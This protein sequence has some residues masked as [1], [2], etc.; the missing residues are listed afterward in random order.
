MV[1]IGVKVQQKSEKERSI[2]RRRKVRREGRNTQSARRKR[3]P[4]KNCND[5]PDRPDRLLRFR[6]V[7]GCN[8]KFGDG[9]N[10]S[11][12]MTHKIVFSFVGRE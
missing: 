4:R 12:L 2:L 9:G 6:T 3:T 1:G 11:E 7:N 8:L 10:T 5:T